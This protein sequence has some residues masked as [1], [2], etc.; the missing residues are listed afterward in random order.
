MSNPLGMLSWVGSAA[1]GLTWGWLLGLWF[2][3]PRPMNRPAAPA[4][5]LPFSRRGLRAAFRVLEKLQNSRWGS[6]LQWLLRPGFLALLILSPVA[7]V[8][9]YGGAGLALM[10][11]VAAAAGFWLQRAWREYLMAHRPDFAGERTEQR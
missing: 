8:W 6:R 1:F 2:A 3:P 10:S 4:D 11:A 5:N 9:A 7:E